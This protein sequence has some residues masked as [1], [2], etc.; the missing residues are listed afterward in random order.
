MP[1]PGAP[2]ATDN[3]AH[4]VASEFVASVTVSGRNDDNAPTADEVVADMQRMASEAHSRGGIDVGSV[5]ETADR[6]APTR[7]DD[8]SLKKKQNRKK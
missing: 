7:T 5:D 8:R 3:L 2:T 6:L 4:V 1:V